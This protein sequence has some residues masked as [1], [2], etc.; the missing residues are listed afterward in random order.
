M[1]ESAAHCNVALLSHIVVPDSRLCEFKL[2]HVGVLSLFYV[3]LSVEYLKVTS[4]SSKKHGLVV[5]SYFEFLDSK[6]N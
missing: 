5:C 3:S 2:L 1:K 6:N 4:K